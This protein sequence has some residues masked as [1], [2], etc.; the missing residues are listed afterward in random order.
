MLSI[1]MLSV[2][3]LSVVTPQTLDLAGILNQRQ[4]HW[5]CD[6]V[7]IIITIKSLFLPGRHQQD[8]FF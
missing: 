2:V 6:R 1:I 5:A 7:I 8:W 4:G 3:M